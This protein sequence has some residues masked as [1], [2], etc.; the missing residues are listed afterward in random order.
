MREKYSNGDYLTFKSFIRFVTNWHKMTTRLVHNNIKVFYYIRVFQFIMLS[1][2][3]TAD[4]L[5]LM[6]IA[7]ESQ[8]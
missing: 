8:I 1:M 2:A 3:N 7:P 5:T 4:F 6:N